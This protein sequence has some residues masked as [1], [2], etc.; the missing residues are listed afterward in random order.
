MPFRNHDFAQNPRFFQISQ[1]FIA[2]ALGL[3]RTT[4]SPTF[5]LWKINTLCTFECKFSFKTRWSRVTWNSSDSSKWEI[6][7]GANLIRNLLAFSSSNIVPARAVVI[8][9]QSKLFSWIFEIWGRLKVQ[10]G[11]K[12]I[13]LFISVNF[14]ARQGIGAR[15]E[16]YK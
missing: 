4:W 7:S 1:D 11:C 2:S 16:A 12:F 5:F 10:N 9:F 13:R 3:A 15:L 6:T 8:K 14:S